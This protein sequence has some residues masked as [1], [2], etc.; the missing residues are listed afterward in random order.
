M[1]MQA[2]DD[3]LVGY[4]AKKHGPA[5]V[6]QPRHISS[7]VTALNRPVYKSEFFIRSGGHGVA[8]FAGHSQLGLQRRVTDAIER[9]WAQYGLRL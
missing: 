4:V 1:P 9:S 2:L 5:A 6:I 7:T 8:V 3:S